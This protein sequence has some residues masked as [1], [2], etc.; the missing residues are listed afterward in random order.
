MFYKIYH[1][2]ELINIYQWLAKCGHREKSGHLPV[3]INK[4]LVEHSTF[5]NLT[6]VYGHV[7]TTWE[8]FSSYSRDHMDY[9]V[10]NIC[11]LALYKKCLLTS[12]IDLFY[13][14]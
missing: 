7:C 8:E 5:I 4:I 12:D 2:R 10:H 9:K 6:V 1:H 14:I 13:V 3:F 11:Y